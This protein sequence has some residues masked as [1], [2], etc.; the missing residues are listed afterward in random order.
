MGHSKQALCYG[1]VT[2]ASCRTL[3]FPLTLLL[4]LLAYFLLVEPTRLK[5][6]KPNAKF[7]SLAVSAA[8]SGHKDDSDGIDDGFLNSQ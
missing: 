8:V 7:Q 4:E 1:E 5:C 2:A 6:F 3:C